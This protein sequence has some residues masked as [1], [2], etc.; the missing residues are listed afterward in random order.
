MAM[1][2]MEKDGKKRGDLRLPALWQGPYEDAGDF[3]V[4]YY[5][6]SGIPAVFLW[7]TKC[8]FQ[9]ESSW[10]EFTFI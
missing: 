10:Y 1:S 4:G 2:L 3:Q 7:I 8:F 9:F 6:S 5:C